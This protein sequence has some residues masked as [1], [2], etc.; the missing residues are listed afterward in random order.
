M[1]AVTTTSTSAIPSGTNLD[2]IRRLAEHLAS[3]SIRGYCELTA[4]PGDF[5]RDGACHE[6]AVA[7]RWV[8]GFADS[9]CEQHAERVKAD[10]ALV[11]YPKRHNGEIS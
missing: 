9:V 2:T 6:K 5:S 11:I 4:L 3:E 10:G 1:S 8:D 7:I